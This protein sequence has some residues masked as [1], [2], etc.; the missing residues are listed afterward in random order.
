MRNDDQYGAARQPLPWHG[1]WYRVGAD[2]HASITAFRSRKWIASTDPPSGRVRWRRRAAN[3]G[4]LGLPV[5]FRRRRS[6]VIPDEPTR[7]DH[8]TSSDLYATAGDRR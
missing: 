3:A 2:D 6:T 7:Q 8:E 4:W 1:Q 5:P